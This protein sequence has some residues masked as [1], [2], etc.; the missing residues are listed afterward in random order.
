MQ[1]DK[2]EFYYDEQGRKVFTKHYH[3]KRGYCCQS[4]CRHCPYGYK[5]KVDPNIPAELQDPWQVK[6]ETTQYY[7][8]PIEE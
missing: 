5:D 3:L 2:K 4:G 8:V 7:D 6:E 1:T